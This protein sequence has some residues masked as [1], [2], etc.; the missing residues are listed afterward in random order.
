MRKA[1]Y[2][3]GVL[4]DS[5]IEWI[6][7]NGRKRLVSKGTQLITEGSPVESLFILLEGK[8][9]VQTRASRSPIA[10]LSSGEIIGEI[11]FVDLRLPTASVTAAENSEVLGIPQ[12]SLRRKL[13]SDTGFAA[14][15]YRAIALYLAD[16]LRVTSGRLGY[17]D[18]RQDDEITDEL[19]DVLMDNAALGASRFDGLL[20]Q[21]SMSAVAVG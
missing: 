19:D 16:R 2:I 11:S 3:M 21:V 20:R 12:S 8:L 5:D 10:V 1:L 7:S 18:S 9:L 6:A 13:E 14:R 17:G 15:F 4:D